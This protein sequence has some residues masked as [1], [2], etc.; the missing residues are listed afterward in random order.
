LRHAVLTAAFA[1]HFFEIKTNATDAGV[2][3]AKNQIIAGFAAL[4]IVINFQ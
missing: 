2:P 3:T 1:A 4:K